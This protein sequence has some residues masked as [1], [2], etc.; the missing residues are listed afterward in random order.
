MLHKTRGIIL[1]TVK[2]SE[3]SIITKIYTEK[4]GLQTYIINGVRTGR[5]GK[6]AL[7]QHG[8]ILDLVVYY[9]ETGNIMRVSEAKIEVL[10][11]QIPFTIYKS[12]L[13][14][15]CIEILNKVVKEEEPNEVLFEF[16]QRSFVF[17][18]AMESNVSN[19][20][21]AFLLQLSSFLGFGPT[22]EAGEYFDL[23]EGVFESTIPEHGAFMD[24][25]ISGILKLFLHTGMTV[26]HTVKLSAAQR[27]TLLQQLLYY[28]R[29]HISGFG[30]MHSPEI[31]S[32]VMR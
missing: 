16:I 17:L 29:L 26:A 20:H 12:A 9:K 10:Y 30:E 24:A 32:M 21:I 1:K 27:R 14:L 6:A 31:L 22:Q 11:T 13:V 23:R 28:Y 2:Y 25:D 5:S 4:F 19:F 7:Y 8:N 3:S 18:D 15:F